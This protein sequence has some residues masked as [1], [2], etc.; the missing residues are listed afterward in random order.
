MHAVAQIE[1]KRSQLITLLFSL[2]SSNPVQF[3]TAGPV[4]C[5]KS[6]IALSALRFP[7]VGQVN[8]M[9]AKSPAILC[10]DHLAK[11]VRG[12][13]RLLEELLLRIARVALL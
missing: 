9:D 1:M 11:L 13:I 5:P 3:L 10:G 6:A 8:G 2:P 4:F 12:L 7:S